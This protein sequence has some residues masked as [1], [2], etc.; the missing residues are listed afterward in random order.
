LLSVSP[1][2]LSGPTWDEVH[3][4]QP[5]QE[6]LPELIQ[7]RRHLHRHPELSGHERQTAALVAG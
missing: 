2:Q 1:A 3:L 4:E 7:L 5:L 6:L